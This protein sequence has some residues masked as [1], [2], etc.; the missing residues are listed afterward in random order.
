[1]PLSNWT[2]YAYLSISSLSYPLSHTHVHAQNFLLFVHCVVFKHIDVSGCFQVCDDTVQYI[3]TKCVYLKNLNLRNCRKLT[4]VALNHL[5]KCNDTKITALHL[6]GNFNLT[7]RYPYNYYMLFL[8]NFPLLVK[9][10]SRCLYTYIYR[11][12]SDLSTSVISF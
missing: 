3:I 9:S 10:M 2:W 1:M 11:E 7:G 4:D 5:V 6:G 12:T 8:S